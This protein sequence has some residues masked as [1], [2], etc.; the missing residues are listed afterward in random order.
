MRH[1]VVL[2]FIVISASA[3][4]AQW[5]T[6]VTGQIGVFMNMSGALY[7]SGVCVYDINDDGWDDITFIVPNDSVVVYLNQQ[8]VFTPHRI[9]RAPGQQQHGVWADYDNDGDADLYV[10]VFIGVSRLFRND[11]NLQLTD[12]TA[13]SG[14][15]MNAQ[16]MTYG[17]AWGDLDA[18]GWLDLYVA[19]YNTFQP[20]SNWFYHNNGD[21]TFTEMAQAL[22]IHHGLSYHLQPVFVDFNHD[23]LE[24][25]YVINDRP[26][27]DALFR[28]NAN[29]TFSEIASAAGINTIAN[30]MSASVCD[31]DNDNDFDFF[32]TNSFPETSFLWRNNGD[33]TFTN[34]AAQTGT[35]V[36]MSGWAALWIDHDHDLN[37]DLMVTTGSGIPQPAYNYMY[38]NN[39]DG[40]FSQEIFFAAQMSPYESFTIGKGDFNNDGYYDMLLGNGTGY[41]SQVYYNNGGPNHWLKL[42]LRGVQSNRDGV[43]TRV[44][45]WLGGSQYTD[46]TLC[47]ENYMSQSSRYL[48]LSLG[49]HTVVDSLRLQWSS[50]QED[51]YYALQADRFLRMIEG[52]EFASL[53]DGSAYGFCPAEPAVITAPEG[54]SWLWSTGDTTQ[55]IAVD[56]PGLYWCEI[57]YGNGSVRQTE[58]ANAFLLPSPVVGLTVSPV[59][60]FGENDGEVELWISGSEVPQAVWWNGEPSGSVITDLG[61]GSYS[62]Q[63]Q[64]SLGCIGEG[65]VDIIEPMPLFYTAQVSPASCHD[66]QD[67][68][69]EITGM[70]GGVQPV[71]FIAIHEETGAEYPDLNGLGG[72]TYTVQG[73]DANGCVSESEVFV[74][75][76]EP[77]EVEVIWP[78]GT[79]TAED[80]PE[81]VVEGGTPPYSA[82]WSNGQTGFQA[83]PFAEGQGHVELT[84]ALGCSLEFLFD[85]LADV[86]EKEGFLIIQTGNT[87]E[88]SGM[89]AF[90]SGLVLDAS[91]RVMTHLT[92][93]P[94]VDF[95]GWASGCYQV[96]LFDRHKGRFAHRFCVAS[97]KR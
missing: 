10:T 13:E 30:S 70:I 96:V 36:N 34:V 3:A 24:D 52:E 77:L 62:Y 20:I 76:P 80:L 31:Y 39:G 65:F 16:A 27:L 51:W 78:G 2:L 37:D 75:A 28:Q 81:V 35:S 97:A 23:G 15:V 55:V 41:Q 63:V 50:G 26:P 88:V 64:D 17:A 33:E 44:D 69:I 68:A 46:Y 21:G 48:I 47:G 9:V 43:G 5:F 95:S 49:A 6:R 11:G 66:T 40:T 12:V 73:T 53:P 32:V 90:E 83:G 45:Y 42:D 57:S 67:G 58:W 18:D 29:G 56:E 14:M 25:I 22:N 89:P 72:G 71:T 94:A 4:S 38:H 60:C 79:P 85:V 7:G 91:G 1:C 54:V 93:R 92:Q 61:P 84:D 87:W 86:G 19:N 82:E 59:S 8:G 74:Y